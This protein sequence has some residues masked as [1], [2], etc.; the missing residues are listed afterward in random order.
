MAMTPF[1]LKKPSTPAAKP[2]TMEASDKVLVEL[3]TR[4]HDLYRQLAEL[5]NKQSQFVRTGDAESLMSILGVRAGIIEQIE[6][7]DK[8][9][10]PY[11]ENWDASLSKLSQHD[12]MTAQGL[13][14]AVQQ[15]LSQILKQDEEDRKL[16]MEQKQQVGTQIRQAVTGSVV[17]KAYGVKPKSNLG[18]FKA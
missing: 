18:G 17:N 4:Q 5:A 8:Q 3:L 11:R 16:L 12:R 13:M 9:I 2:V 7:L 1:S 6:P 10:H 15:L 14:G